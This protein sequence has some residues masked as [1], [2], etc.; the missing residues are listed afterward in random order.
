MA[1]CDIIYSSKDKFKIRPLLN[2]ALKANDLQ[3]FID[4]ITRYNTLKQQVRL[5]PKPGDSETEVSTSLRDLDNDIQ[6]MLMSWDELHPNSR[7]FNSALAQIR[8]ALNIID[9]TQV[10]PA[11]DAVETKTRDEVL[12]QNTTNLRNHLAEFYGLEAFDITS[13]LKQHF[14]D[15]MAGVAYYDI[16]SGKLA[17]QTNASLNKN[18]QGL[19]SK[20]FKTIVSYLKENFPE[21]AQ[22]LSDDM[23]VGGNVDVLNLYKTLNLFYSKV[24]SQDNFKENLKAAHADSVSGTLKNAKTETYKN[25]IRTLM[26]DKTFQASMK[27]QYPGQAFLNFQTQL[28]DADHFSRY[29][30]EVEGYVADN[31]P[32]LMGVIEDIKKE[33]NDLLSASNAYTMLR[34]FDY[35]LKNVYGDQVSIKKGTTGHE[36][37]ISDK[38]TYHKDTSHE[39]KGWQ[40][41]ESISSEQHIARFTQAVVNMIRIYNYKTGEF[42]HRR[43]DNTML[44]VAAR[45]F[46]N[47]IITNKIK[48][49][50]GVE[51][52]ASEL[53]GNVLT[54]HDD[55]VVKLQ[56]ILELLFEKVPG[57][58]YPLEHYI[59]DRRFVNDYDLSVL[60][61][62]YDVVFNVN[63]KNSFY[64]Q[65]IHNAHLGIETAQ[66]LLEEIA[67]LVDRNITVSYAETDFDY[68]TGGVRI[69]VKKKF[70]SDLNE[71]K[72]QAHI[73]GYI[74]KLPW[75]ERVS[76]QD[77]YNFRSLLGEYDNSYTV[78]V[79]GED[80]TL[81]VPS[82]AT[83]QLL[84]FSSK[85]DKPMTFSFSE[86]LLD[87]LNAVNLVS[88][89]QKLEG[90]LA[91]EPDEKLLYDILTFIDDTLDLKL[92]SL[93]GTNLQVLQTYKDQYNPIEGFDNYLEPLLKMAIRA[94]YIN[95]NYVKT[96][97]NND[98]AT[99]LIETKDPVYQEFVADSKSKIF[100]TRFNHLQYRAAS[101]YD[102]VL[103]AW[104]EAQSVLSGEAS[105][106]TTKDKQGNSIPNNSVAKAGGILHYYLVKQLGSDTES[107]M[108]VGGRN[109]IV[110]TLHDL[111]ATSLSGDS[112]TIRQF[113]TSELA[114]HTIFNK[115]FGSYLNNDTVIIQPTAYSDKT[116][117]LNWEINPKF[118]GID[119]VRAD[120]RQILEMYA[121][122]IGIAY[123]NVYQATTRKLQT[124]TAEFVKENGLSTDMDY[125][126]VMHLMTEKDLV[127]IASS[128]GYKVEL[129]KDY[130]IVVHNGK[131]VVGVNALLGYNADLYLNLEKLDKKLSVEKGLFLEHLIQSGSS[132]QVLE[133]RDTI[134]MYTQPDVDPKATTRNPILRTISQFFKDDFNARKDYMSNWVDPATGKMILAKQGNVNIVSVSDKY[135]RHSPIELNPLLDKFFYA[136]GLMSNNLRYSLTGFEVN[137]PAGKKSP[138]T[139]AM[140]AKDLKSWN[141]LGI[142]RITEKTWKE[143]RP[144]LS[145]V[146]DLDHLNRKYQSMKGTLSRPTQEAVDTLLE[147]SYNYET[148]TSQGTQFKRNVIIP[149]TLQYCTQD[150][151]NGIPPRIK[152]AVVRDVGAPVFNYRGDHDGEI[153]SCD[154]SAKITPFQSIMENKALGSQA[155][156]FVKKPIWHAYD[157]DSGTAFLAKF[158][159]NTMTNE[160][161]R[162]S[163]LSN[164]KLYN[165]FKKA[166]NLQWDQPIDLTKALTLTESLGGHGT[167]DDTYNSWVSKTILGDQKLFYKDKYGNKTEIVSFNKETLPDGSVVYYT[168]ERPSG[169]YTPIKK[170]H[171][172]Y[173]EG[174]NTSIHVMEDSLEKIQE[175]KS[176]LDVEGKNPH[177]INSL[178]ELHAALGGIYCVDSE[179]KGSEFNN[180]V[181]VNFMNNVGSAKRG[182]TSSSIV[183]QSTYEQ[184]L[185]QYHIGYVLNNTAV[186]NGAS[187]INPSSSWSDDTPFTYFEVDSDGLG[188]QMNA[189]HD[190]INSELT[191]FS[192]VIAATAAYGYTYDNTYEIFQGLAKTAFQASEKLHLAT[193]EFLA[194]LRGGDKAKAISELYDAVGRVIMMNQ[195]I[196][197][198]ESLTN[199]IIGAVQKVFNKYS[200]HTDDEVKIPFS[201][202]NVYGEFIST[203][204]SVITNQSIKRKHPGSGCV[205]VPAYDMI[206]YFELP[207]GNGGYV[208]LMADDIVKKARN[209]YKAE[210]VEYL[211][212]HPGYDAETGMLTIDGNDI[213]LTR[214]SLS[215]LESIAL[216][217]DPT[218]QFSKY[219]NAIQDV[220]LSHQA[221]I[222]AY[223][224]QH[225][226]QER[227]KS[228]FMPSDIVEVLDAEGNIVETV[229]LNSLDKYYR[230][231]EGYGQDGELYAP[232]YRYRVSVTSPHNLRPSLIRWQ[233]VNANGIIEYMNAF[234]LPAIKDAYL[235]S[236][237]RD[238]NYRKKVQDSLHMLHDGKFMDSN[239]V[240][241]DIVEGSLENLEAELIMSNL[242]QETFGIGKESLSEVLEMGEEFF[243]N[244]TKN[245]KAPSNTLYDLVFLR[246]N[247]KHTMITVG[248]LPADPSLQEEPM[249]STFT[250]EKD[251]IMLVHNGQEQFMVG[252]WAEPESSDVQYDEANGRFESTSGG[253]VDQTKYR[254]KDGKIQ[255]RYDFIRRYKAATKKSTRNGITLQSN[256]LYQVADID[257][258]KKALGSDDNTD[259][260][261]LQS[262]ILNR[263]YAIGDYKLAQINPGKTLSENSR[264]AITNAIQGLVKDTTIEQDVK[265]L[266]QMQ[267]D[268]LDENSEHNLAVLTEAKEA[269]RRKEARR[270]WVSFQ[271]SLKFI[272]SRIPA[273]TLQS[274][275]AMKCVAWTQNSNNMC[276]VSHFQEYLQGSKLNII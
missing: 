20:L 122:T 226:D 129:H 132:F 173:D 146:V 27:R 239:G 207:D 201:D 223:L 202:P 33:N 71:H 219:Y 182:Q 58:N 209:E 268:N 37:D 84:G 263:I 47:G 255:Q 180:E 126:D 109:M 44:I 139:R 34:Y 30:A 246:G 159:T 153:D 230:F 224:E 252:K 225:Q 247:G 147:E 52:Q 130:R 186:K 267:L 218:G 205:M 88:L 24:A 93:T 269:F 197:D 238:A 28:Y 196:K 36:G 172:F 74:N 51:E 45:N 181:V 217:I 220:S 60:K 96:G 244:Q 15:L 53:I 265:E 191:E 158:A 203:L 169:T 257:T 151:K 188:M 65:D 138:L 77:Q 78:T 145:D 140:K 98:L 69:K 183:N 199:V 276:Y 144:L 10:A 242:Y 155:V 17:D 23:Y 13:K 127:R 91:L 261:A 35:M 154:G 116:T 85:K 59:T 195:S 82:T 149:A 185:K 42:M 161:M 4:Y 227:D 66:S 175:R 206:Q 240:V 260:I 136:E 275:M 21:E 143:L 61:S 133:G 76:L 46:I 168:L 152:C 22:A 89:R 163:I 160:E 32:D 228:F 128:I 235:N 135:D 39:R 243:L 114:F 125:R 79:G 115:F 12:D 48:F 213:N 167:D 215:T 248:N 18:I 187:N 101:F 200:D 271:D 112:K 43:A 273:Q 67:S 274:F 92:T 179:S 95:Y 6:A 184:P 56:N 110:N 231:K 119:I 38:Y 19:K 7:Q 165:V 113:S 72:L 256:T 11:D 123:D 73:N 193:E 25:L 5:V 178:F 157:S 81:N 192:Q 245:L 272:S 253:N 264:N 75:D 254:V 87:R 103:N 137:H 233:Y 266:L 171:L 90:K 141:A 55:P 234:D 49:S 8:A 9:E 164:T 3:D 105:K 64:Y 16:N 111:E 258:F 107:L 190:I 262:A 162:M 102:K 1:G 104:V 249:T 106:A 142:A 62:I 121:N 54:M 31:R 80:I 99:Y 50:D 70:F 40:T 124:I 251:E 212:Q 63:R 41:S 108:F 204:A 14:M 210:L 86:G 57:K 2:K 270:K 198:K 177:T 94:A 174:T 221:M 97:E 250:N 26:L 100:S 194:G 117:F 211:S 83:G 208:K 68:N 29:F 150:V 176:L 216:G 148:N 120:K 232:N 241:H 214:T 259:A 237:S 236:E 134:D 166:T 118:E 170:Y 189:D 156:G 131:K 229:G 222:R